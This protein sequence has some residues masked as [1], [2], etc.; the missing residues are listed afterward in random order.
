MGKPNYV[1][2]TTKMEQ[3]STSVRVGFGE[4]KLIA[5]KN[6]GRTRISHENIE[7]VRFLFENNTR[8]SIREAES[9]LSTSS[10]TTQRVLKKNLFVYTYKCRISMESRT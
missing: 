10:S 9:C 5:Q 2:N 6:N 1:E 8:L 4:W 3:N 7:N